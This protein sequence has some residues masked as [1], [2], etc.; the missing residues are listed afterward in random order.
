MA[1]KRDC[2]DHVPMWRFHLVVGRV[3]WRKPHVSFSS[4]R[5]F[6]VVVFLKDDETE[7]FCFHQ[8]GVV[9]SQ[10]RFLTSTF[11]DSFWA[12][13]RHGKS[14]YSRLSN[15][16]TS[17]CSVRN[18]L[19]PSSI[20][21]TRSSWLFETESWWG[22]NV[23]D[24]LLQR[25]PS[26]LDALGVL[27][28]LALLPTHLLWLPVFSLLPGLTMLIWLSKPLLSAYHSPG[29]CHTAVRERPEAHHWELKFRR[30]GWEIPH[31]VWW[32]EVYTPG[33]EEVTSQLSRG[34][35]WGGD[36]EACRTARRA[37]G[38]RHRFKKVRSLI[39]LF[40]GAGGLGGRASEELQ[41][42]FL[43]QSQEID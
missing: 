40:R 16:A 26:D 34:K 28:P 31:G 27:L 24:G 20:W 18:L 8:P 41:T 39:L 43:G 21:G 11:L 6:F 37:G 22:T 13:S 14:M 29:L 9:T 32:H 36:Q 33:L 12:V 3:C 17:D 1:S 2:K 25:K 15:Q 38:Q 4:F 5:F 7:Q 19:L 42:R 30:A 10:S 35:G 23:A